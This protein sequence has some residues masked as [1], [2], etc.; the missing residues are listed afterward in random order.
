V[1]VS[2]EPASGSLFPVGVSTV[3][4]SSLDAQGNRGEATFRVTVSGPPASDPG[5]PPGAEA[6]AT[7]LDLGRRL[8]VVRAGAR[9]LDVTCTLDRPVLRRCA[10]SLVAGGK[11][12]ARAAADAPTGAAAVTVALPL[13]AATV[14][15]ARRAGGLAATLQGTAEQA[16]SGP[17]LGARINVLLLPG[18]VVTLPSDAL[19]RGGATTL[20][21]KGTAALRTLRDALAGARRITCTGH[22]DDRGATAA[23]QRLGLARARSVCAFL[24]R[25]TTL[26]G[27]AA[28]R[29]ETAPRASNRSAAGRA[30]NRRVTVAVEF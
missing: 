21:A 2:C 29:G 16:G 20:P 11:T 9:R 4:C 10:V 12:L 6:P 27:Q 18:P 14:R 25:G 28:S 19:F 23:N 26:A 1:Q 30:A 7:A 8:L 17:A 5:A 15:L 13:D 22:T 24:T 3:T